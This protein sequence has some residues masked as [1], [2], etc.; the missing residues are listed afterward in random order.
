MKQAVAKR[1]KGKDIVIPLELIPT[2]SQS[3]HPSPATSVNP[4]PATSANPSPACT[5]G[6]T[7]S[8]LPS[9]GPSGPTVAVATPQAPGRTS[10][11]ILEPSLYLFVIISFIAITESISAA[12][13][14][15]LRRTFSAWEKLARRL[16]CYATMLSPKIRTNL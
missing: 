13:V 1:P 10:T 8:P 12:L 9:L 11:K 7:L 6:P 4:S 15:H 2:P 5:P 3:L 14:S 16:V